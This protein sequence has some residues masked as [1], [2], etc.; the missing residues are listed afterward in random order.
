MPRE[1][2][3]RNELLSAT[4]RRVPEIPSQIARMA[5]DLVIDSLAEALVRGN[6]VALRGFGTFIPRRYSRSSPG[7]KKVGLVFHPCPR[8]A[9]IPLKDGKTAPLGRPE[10]AQGPVLPADMDALD[11]LEGA[12]AG[13]KD[14]PAAS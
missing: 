7:T 1:T 2:L 6:T 5:A 10:T 4:A 11:A 12:S 3:T 14:A 9:D 13:M 8:L